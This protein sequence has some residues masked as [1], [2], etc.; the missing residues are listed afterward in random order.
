LG[1]NPEKPELFHSK[2]TPFQIGF[3]DDKRHGTGKLCTRFATDAPNVRYVFTR[4]PAV[5]SSIV[6]LLGAIVIGFVYGW[7]LALILLAI[8]PLL[9]ASGY[10]EFKMQVSGIWEK[11]FP[12]KFE[13]FL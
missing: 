3:Y 8:I 6:T 2:L 4:L 9:F 1:I 12:M 13:Y 11:I 7:K 5:I 10:F